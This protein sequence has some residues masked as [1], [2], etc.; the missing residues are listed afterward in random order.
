MDYY[1]Y[2]RE[3][4]FEP[5]GMTH[6][7]W[8]EKSDLPG[9]IARGYTGKGREVNYGTLPQRGSSA[10]GG[11]CTAEDLLRYVQALRA[12][13]LRLPGSERGLGIAGGAPGLNAVLDWMPERA[14]I[15]VVLSNF[16]PPAAER[17]ARRIRRTLPEDQGSK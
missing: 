16:D 8:F 9:D 12:G 2:V 13:I 7:G 17:I 11:Y 14:Y 3:H 5:A 10:G 6:A 1:S 4:I 15:V